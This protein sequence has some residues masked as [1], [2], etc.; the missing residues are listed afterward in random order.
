M[1]ALGCAWRVGGSFRTFHA[2]GVG[3]IW[4]N[5][6]Q[7]YTYYCCTAELPFGNTVLLLPFGSTILLLAPYLLLHCYTCCSG[8]VGG[9]W[10]GGGLVVGASGGTW[11]AGG[12]F[13]TWIVLFVLWGLALFCTFFFFLRYTGRKLAYSGVPLVL[14]IAEGYTHRRWP[15]TSWAS[16]KTAKGSQNRIS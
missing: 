10:V 11:R 7:P 13:R 8:L 6:L 15:A 2:V 5:G 4:G 9:W 1:G 14:N 16:Q 3:P 12:S